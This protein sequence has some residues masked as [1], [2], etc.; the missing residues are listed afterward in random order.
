MAGFLYFEKVEEPAEGQ[1]DLHFT[2][3]DADSREVF[4][5][6]EIPFQVE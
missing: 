4:G 3:V 2:L 6:I 5:E 1:V